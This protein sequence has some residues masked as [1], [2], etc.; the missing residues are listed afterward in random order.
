MA[1][2]ENMRSKL[3]METESQRLVNMDL[4]QL[5]NDLMK[6]K[7]V[8]QAQVEACMEAIR[9]VRL[10]IDKRQSNVDALTK[11]LEKFT[12]KNAVSV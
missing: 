8:M 12:S 11:K 5:C 2:N 6:E 9:K 1:N 10:A 7:D 3:V 4:Q